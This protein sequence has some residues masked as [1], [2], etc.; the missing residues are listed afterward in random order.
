M[1]KLIL[2]VITLAALSGCGDPNYQHDEQD[3]KTLIF[4]VVSSSH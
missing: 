3:T 2:A 4:P 1:I